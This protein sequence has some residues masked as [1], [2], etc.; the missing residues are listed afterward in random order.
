M[1][2]A[3]VLCSVEALFIILRMSLEQFEAI[4]ISRDM[5]TSIFSHRY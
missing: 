2:N 3:L 5:K 1:I 4:N